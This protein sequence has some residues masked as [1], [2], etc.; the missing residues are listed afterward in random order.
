MPLRIARILLALLALGLAAPA[1]AQTEIDEEYYEELLEDDTELDA[2]R[3]ETTDLGAE[4]AELDAQIG[5]LRISDAELQA[6]VD[7]L[8]IEIFEQQAA[9]DEA[10]EAR[11]E[12]LGREADALAE[13][14]DLEEEIE[15]LEEL[16]TLR[17]VD[18]YVRPGNSS[19][20]RLL[21]SEDVNDLAKRYVFL[22]MIAEHETEVADELASSRGRIEKERDAADAAGVEARNLLEAAGVSLGELEAAKDEQQALKAELQARIAHVQA[23]A[24]AL[25]AAQAEIQ[26]LIAAREA[27]YRAAAEERAR[28]KDLCARYA[29]P[30]DIDGSDID[31]EAIGVAPPSLGWPVAGWVSSE[32]GPRWGRMHEGI[33]IAADTGA[34]VVASA[35]GEA[36]FVGWIGGY[37]NTILIDHGGGLTT[38]YAHLDSF[39]ISEGVDVGQGQ[40]IA[41]VGNSGNSQGPHLHFETIQDGGKVDP[42]TYLP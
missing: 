15:A 10:M 40:T 16:L 32:F 8:E 36:Y 23:E 11:L 29:D 9:Y 5:S 7:Q 3:D 34:P 18:A 27:E 26:A 6:R 35:A 19:P 30:V 21:A 14:H 22:E 41:Y 42:R 2:Q 24:D 20:L 38:L 13:V 31:C 28:H 17:A 1:A 12:A 37:G 25:A 33:D 39:A 4:K